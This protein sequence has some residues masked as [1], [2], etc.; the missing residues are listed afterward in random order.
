VTKTER[1]TNAGLPASGPL[2]VVFS[3]AVP[4]TPT[5]Y[6]LAWAGPKPAHRE[7]GFVGVAQ[8]TFV[9]PDPFV[10]SE[11]RAAQLVTRHDLRSRYVALHRD[12][13]VPKD[14]E[15]TAVLR[16]K[17]AWLRSRRRGILAG[18]SASALHGSKW[19]DPTMPA[20]IIDTNRRKAPGVHVWEERIEADEIAIVNDMR[21]TTPARTALDLARRYPRGIAVAAVDALVRATDLKMADVELL[22]DRYRGRHGMK[23]ARAALELVDGGAQSPKETWLRLLLISAGFP[24]PQT[25][26]RVLNEFGWTEAYLDMGWEDIKLAVEYDGDQHRS[27]RYQYV[28]DIRRLEKWSAT[29]GG[30]WFESS[31]RTI[32]PTSSAVWPKREPAARNATAKS[33]PKSRPDVTCVEKGQ[34]KARWE[35]GG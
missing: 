21:V 18:F 24:R 26:I 23:A 4:V 20:E 25:Q 13:Y 3:V 10:G 8:H 12:V 33:R 28:K 15:L 22:V 35:A 2:S 32:P 9:M 17:A 30:S 14:A 1:D 7:R 31:P 11:A 19:I 27:S 29:M 5:T 6:R 34:G 16:A